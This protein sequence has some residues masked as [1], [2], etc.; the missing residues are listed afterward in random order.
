[1]PEDHKPIVDVD[2]SLVKNDP[3]FHN[4][5]HSVEEVELKV[6]RFF[7][8]CVHDPFFQ[9]MASHPNLIS[10]ASAMIGEDLKILQSMAICKPPGS[11]IKRWH[12][13]NAYFRLLP[14]DV[15]AFW[16]AV[17]SATVE[18]GCMHVVPKSHI[19]GISEHG[20][21]KDVDIPKGQEHSFFSLL[22]TPPKDQ[23][24]AVPLEPGDA[25]VFHGELK[26]FT[27]PNN[28]MVRRRALQFH[29]ASSYCVPTN[30]Q[31]WYYRKG[32]LLVH[33]KDLGG[34]HI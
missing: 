8:M 21:P 4:R 3:E 18:N 25:L 17:D 10:I 31:F 23:I 2:P 13:D 1:M 12:Q 24:V 16:I 34:E 5:A 6:R 26:H 19:N 22:E 9:K 30:P 15:M 33:G 7:R 28:T 32:E 11:G 20:I 14:N 29:Y 27:P